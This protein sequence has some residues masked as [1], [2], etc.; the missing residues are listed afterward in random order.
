MDV[1]RFFFKNSKHV[2]R[3]CRNVT[4]TI[5]CVSCEIEAKLADRKSEQD[6]REKQQKTADNL[7]ASF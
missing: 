3:F 1:K 2:T 7:K 4:Q 5:F 6:K